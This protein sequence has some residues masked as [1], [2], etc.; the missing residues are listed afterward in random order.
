[1]IQLESEAQESASIQQR[2]I[3]AQTEVERLS[4]EA[5]LHLKD[6][7]ARLSEMAA[8]E[9][10]EQNSYW[11]TRAA[12]AEQSAASAI[13]KKDERAKEIM[14][15]DARRVELASRLQDAENSLHGLDAEKN[16]LRE[17]ESG[18]HGQIEEMRIQI[19]A[20]GVPAPHLKG[21]LEGDRFVQEVGQALAKAPDPQDHG[22]EDNGHQGQLLSV[23][24]NW[25]KRL[26]GSR[27]GSSA[28]RRR[29]TSVRMG[30][31]S[32]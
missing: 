3:E 17:N 4:S 12:V 11:S 20:P 24:S 9:L 2:L 16:N 10:Q 14:R 21:L 23:G 30:P 22:Q 31:E 28:P 26:H 25:R 27:Q 32:N 15:L 8:D 18:L 5:Q 7:S 13:A 1:M 29:S 19:D 6:I